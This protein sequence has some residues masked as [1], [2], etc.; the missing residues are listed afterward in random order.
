MYIWILGE[1]GLLV[2]KIVKSFAASEFDGYA[3][4][5]ATEKKIIYDVFSHGDSAFNTGQHLA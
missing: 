2:G 1:A 3:D 4:K 5:K